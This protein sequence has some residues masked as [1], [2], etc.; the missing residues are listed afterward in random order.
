MNRYFSKEIWIATMN[1]KRCSKSLAIREMKIKTMSFPYKITQQVNLKKIVITP[2]GENVQKL[3]LSYIS[4][5]NV[6][7]TLEHSLTVS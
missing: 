1:T 5:G 2:N 4:S 3:D 6:Y 7:G